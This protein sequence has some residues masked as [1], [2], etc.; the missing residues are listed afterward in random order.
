VKFRILTIL[1]FVIAV[2]GCRCSSTS[3]AHVSISGQQKNVSFDVEVVRSEEDRRRGLMFRKDL[4]PSKG[5]LFIF[6]SDENQSFWMDNTKIPLDIVFFD[7]NWK[8]VGTLEGME[9][10]SR[11]S[12]SINKPSRYVLEINA[13]LVQKEHISPG[14]VGLFTEEK[15]NAAN[16]QK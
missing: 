16:V 1:L 15:N 7:S 10:M 13:G 3:G 8:V 9:P 11:L 14:D 6:E 5:M 12:R 2:S 4:A